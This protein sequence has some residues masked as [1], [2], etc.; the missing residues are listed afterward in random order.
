MPNLVSGK[1]G[2]LHLLKNDTI[3]RIFHELEV[4]LDWK[5]KNMEANRI[6]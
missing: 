1:V 6:R 2:H 5:I 3:Q 4:E